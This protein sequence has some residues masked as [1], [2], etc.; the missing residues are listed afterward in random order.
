MGTNVE[1]TTSVK[2][3]LEMRLFRASEG[4]LYLSCE[5]VYVTDTEAAVHVDK[6]ISDMP[7]FLSVKTK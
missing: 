1:A 2:D 3:K 7:A 6:S 5:M 4:N